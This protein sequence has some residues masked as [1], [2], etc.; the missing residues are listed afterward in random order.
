MLRKILVPVRGDGKGDN[1]LAHAAAVAREFNAHIEITHCRAKPEDLLPFGVP[2]PAAVRAQLTQS[3]TELFDAEEAGLRAELEALARTLK[4]TLTDKPTGTAV[5]ASFVEEAGRQIDVIRHHGRL[6]DLIAV[7]KP[8]IDRNIGTNTLKA[9]L[10]STGRPVLMCPDAGGTV[11][12]DLGQ[13][14]VIAWDGSLE[15]SRAV[16]STLPL[17]AAAK[18]VTIVTAKGKPVSVTAE[19]LRDYLAAH[20]VSASLEIIEARPNVARALL[21]TAQKMGADMMILGAYSRNQELERLLGGTTQ[22][23]V[24]HATIPVIM[25]N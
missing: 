17:L 7:A 4:L 22:Y 9:A 20:D 14:I 25:T 3:S 13:N 19:E 18:Q 23:I 2:I 24:D 8:D 5:T 1:V 21:D 6:A 12:P 15:A 11:A 10:F 16:I